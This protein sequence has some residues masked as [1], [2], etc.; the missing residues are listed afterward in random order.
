VLVRIQ[1][2]KTVFMINCGATEDIRSV[3]KFS[4]NVRVIIIDSHRPIWHGY[5]T[6]DQEVVV[7]VDDDD[8]VAIGEIPEYRPQDDK[9]GKTGSTRHTPG[10]IVSTGM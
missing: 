5:N 10:V 1:E 7:V 9:Q 4:P 8:P 3:C 6:E 2:L